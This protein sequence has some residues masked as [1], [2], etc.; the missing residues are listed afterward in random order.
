MQE[1]N[2]AEK[3]RGWYRLDNSAAVYPAI[4][5]DDYSAIY[6]FS[7]VMKKRV[8]PALLQRAVDLTMPRF[9]VFNVCIKKGVFWYYLEPNLKPGPFVKPD[10]AN[11]CMPVRFREDNGYLLRIYFY[12]KRISVEMYHALT[13]GAGA[14]VFLKTLLAEYLRL[15]GYEIPCTLGVKDVAAP[16]EEEEA[17]D[18]YI[19]YATSET[20]RGMK[21][22][23]AYPG[24][25]TRAPFYTL[26]VIS[27]LVSLDELRLTAKSYG[28][29][30]T[31]YLSAVLIRVLLDKQKRE[32]P[33]RLRPVA[34]AVPIDLRRFFPSDTLRNFILNVCPAV[35]PGMG[36]YT[37]EEIVRQVHHYM[38]LNLSR[39]YLRAKMTGNVRL[40]FNPFVSRIPLVMKNP[41]LYINYQRM[42]NR[43]YS[44]TLTNPGV[45][46]VPAAMREHIQRAEMMLGQSFAARAN[47]GCISFGN[48]MAITF[49]GSI[50]EPDVEREFF[51]RLVRDGIH[52]RVE[53]N[54][55]EGNGCHTA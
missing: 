12:E 18:A 20:P 54:R 36:E 7:A 33:H 37:F 26:N 51:R 32:Q 8:D 47:C 2:G 35:N 29:S 14:M 3:S 55:E 21:E 43:Q 46:R 39:Q 52:V 38:R 4:Q 45:F 49:A 41:L 23:K 31:E 10:I 13:D 50:V 17:E 5:R 19:R 48:T 27:G 22:D 24:L 44:A 16:P 25:G 1:K 11:P 28:A 6:R 42:G 30:I 53:S 15:Q 40:R 34:L 9:P